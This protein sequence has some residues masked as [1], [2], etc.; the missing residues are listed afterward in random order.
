MAVSREPALLVPRLDIEVVSDR[1]KYGGDLRRCR[2][3]R[4]FTALQLI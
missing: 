3:R 4:E 1:T 2:V